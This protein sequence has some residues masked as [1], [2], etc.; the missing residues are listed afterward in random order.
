MPVRVYRLYAVVEQNLRSNAPPYTT[1]IERPM[2][3]L[4]H[5]ATSER[6]GQIRLPES[7]PQIVGY[8]CL[9]KGHTTLAFASKS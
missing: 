7:K 3:Y 2:P 4:Y 6:L 9:G 1:P 5:N 8:I